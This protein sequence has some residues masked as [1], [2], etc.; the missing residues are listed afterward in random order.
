[1]DSLTLLLNV[2]VTVMVL[3]F[4][5]WMG[6]LAYLSTKSIITDETHQVDAIG[7]RFFKIFLALIVLVVALSTL[8]RFVRMEE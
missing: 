6:C 7:Y 1:M 5:G 4:A 3:C 8:L 2:V